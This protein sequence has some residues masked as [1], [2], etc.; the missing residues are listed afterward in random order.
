MCPTD[1]VRPE[2]PDAG[3]PSRRDLADRRQSTLGFVAAMSLVALSLLPMLVSGF[4]GDDE[5]NSLMTAKLLAMKGQSLVGLMM[6]EII[7]WMTS[8]GRFFPLSEYARILFL[9]VDGN[10]VTYKIILMALVLLDAALLYALLKRMVG[11][12]GLP[13]VAVL[14]FSATLQFRFYHEPI[15][16]FSGLLPIITA[17]VLAALLSFVR[18]LD[19]RDRRLLLVSVAWFA[20]SLLMYEVALPMCLVFV[21]LAAVYPARAT[22]A[23]TMR[24]S[25]MHLVAAGGAVGIVLV[26]RYG[27]HFVPTTADKVSGYQLNFS[28]VPVVLTVIKQ[29]V[30]AVPLI[31]WGA[32]MVA[33]SLGLANRQLFGSPLTYLR[34]DPILSLVI[35]TVFFGV[36]LLVLRPFLTRRDHAAPPAFRAMVIVGLG[37]LVLPNILI[38]LAARHQLGVGW[39]Q[40]YL[41]VYMS[42]IGVAILIATAL[43]WVAR[44]RVPR[45]AAAILPVVLALGFGLVGAINF[46]NNRLAVEALN[47][48]DFYS[49]RVAANAVSAGLLAPVPDGAWLLSNVESAW[50][51]T[52]FYRLHGNKPLAGAAPLVGPRSLSALPLRRDRLTDPAG[53]TS[54]VVD[55]G[56][57]Q[58]YYLYVESSTRDAGYAVLS[59]VESLTVTSDNVTVSGIPVRAY[60]AWP[61]PPAYDWQAV[62]GWPAR[63]ASYEPANTA[64]PAVSQGTVVASGSDWSLVS[65]PEGW[66][67]TEVG[68][69]PGKGR[70]WLDY[71]EPAWSSSR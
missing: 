70:S 28:P 30:A 50:Q 32:R 63:P 6:Q 40:G 47:R 10:P 33:S 58:V 42:S 24:A 5:A 43:D 38:S 53:S 36:G 67:V 18:Y 9:A 26:L 29:M 22:F 68:F 2:P 12:G 57:P 27:F 20:T 13:T 46:D 16:S 45:L 35:A 49:A 66:T 23:Q 69:D 56:G 17:M 4:F 1:G 61:Q 65:V 21:L 11:Q 48:G 64:G 7:G 34:V 3:A 59:R 71:P 31:P 19:S 44:S 15:L 54:Y 55:P 60:R 25:W 39:G 62:Q 37:F 51:V 41:P 52:D 8:V 14:A